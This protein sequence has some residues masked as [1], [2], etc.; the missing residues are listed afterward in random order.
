MSMLFKGDEV[1]IACV[2]CMAPM[3]P[4]RTTCGSECARELD[5][6]KALVATNTTYYLDPESRVGKVAA[7]LEPGT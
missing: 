6:R 5:W 7:S 3:E 2:I 1:T 4:Y